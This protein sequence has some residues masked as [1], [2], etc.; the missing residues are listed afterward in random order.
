MLFAGGAIA[1]FLLVK[2]AAVVLNAADGR[3]GVGR[4][5]DEIE[6][7]FAGDSEG[8]KGCQ[9]AHLFA[10]LVDYANFACADT[11]VDADKRFC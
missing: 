7:A 4:D 8:F 1:L 11:V 10:V 3:D 9:D 6:S 2:E 5:L